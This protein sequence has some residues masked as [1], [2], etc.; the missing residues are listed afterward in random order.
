MIFRSCAALLVLGEEPTRAS[1][2]FTHYYIYSSKSSS[3][4]NYSLG[5]TFFRSQQQNES[6][7][8]SYNLQSLFWLL[9]DSEDIALAMLCF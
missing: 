5:H 3:A 8:F 6:L 4:L 2:F 9:E 1:A 7:L